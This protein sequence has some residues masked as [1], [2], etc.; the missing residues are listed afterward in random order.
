MPM[1]KRPSSM[2]SGV[3]KGH[4]GLVKLP[5]IQA[6]PL[7][8]PIKIL[9]LT[10]RMEPDLKG[11]RPGRCTILVGHLADGSCHLSIANETRYPTWDEI[12]KARYEL[13]PVDA[14]VA[15]LLPTAEEYINLHSFC[16]QLHELKDGRIPA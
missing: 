6:M 13:M 9:A 2:G 12:A 11:Y 14:M 3:G 8:D 10:G 7:P 16:F 4:K 1:Q 15:M 5:D